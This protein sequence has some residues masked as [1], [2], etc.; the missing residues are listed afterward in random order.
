MKNIV[1]QKINLSVFVIFAAFT[2][3]S[4][5]NVSNRNVVRLCSS[6]T[7]FITLRSTL[8]YNGL[9]TKEVNEKKIN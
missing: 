3:C 7:K 9:D 5:Y 4:S 8:K 2:I 6:T 1:V